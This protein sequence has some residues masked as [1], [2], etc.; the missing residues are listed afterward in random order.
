MTGDVNCAT[1]PVPNPYQDLKAIFSAFSMLIFAFA[2]QTIFLEM[3]AEMKEPKHFTRSLNLGF[4]VMMTLYYAVCAGAYGHCGEHTPTDK[5]TTLV[6]RGPALRVVGLMMLVHM[7]ISYNISS[8][9][10]MRSMFVNTGF[11]IGVEH[12]VK[13]RLAWFVASTSTLVGC[14][15][16]A[17]LIPDFVDIC[18][19]VVDIG[20]CPLCFI[21][22]CSL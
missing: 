14:A 4:A 3:N 5:I 20:I 22:P 10:M 9:V 2:G 1:D 6:E 12:S 13:G 7:V 11:T 17:N 18:G 8:T 15:L 21:L 19:L 16:V